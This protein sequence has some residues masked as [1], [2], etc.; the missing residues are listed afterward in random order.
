MVHGVTAQNLVDFQQSLDWTPVSRIVLNLGTEQQLKKNWH[1]AMSMS[2]E[3]TVCII[4]FCA[5]KLLSLSKMH[6]VINNGFALTWTV[7]SNL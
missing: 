4:Y 7:L 5:F 1:F 6:N 3:I 2:V